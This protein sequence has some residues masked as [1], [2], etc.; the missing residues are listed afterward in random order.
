M[1]GDMILIT[2]GT[3]KTGRRIVQR[4][5][6][7]DRPVRVGSRSGGVPFDW[8]DPDTWQPALEGVTAAYLSYYPDL[9]APGAPEAIGAFAETALRSGTRRLVLL[10]GRGEEE[11]QAGEKVL[12]ASGA[13]WTVL[14]CSWFNQNFSEGY[15]VDGLVDGELLLPAGEVGEPFVDAD[16]IADVATAVLTQDGHLGRIYELTGPRLLTFAEAVAAISAATGRAI[17]YRRIPAEEFAA[18]LAAQ[19][20]PADIV[21]LLTYVF[22]TVLDG[23]NAYVCDGVRQAL[24]RPAR[25]F[26]DYARDAAATGVW[27]G[28]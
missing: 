13:D 1:T 9:A 17:A 16:D 24:G 12:A 7:Q 26:T 11:A 5:T 6:A 4:L 3:G 2:G 14:R 28:R 23:R 19:D 10:S 8:A 15:L 27:N 22:T 18:G 21:D 25:D 20:V